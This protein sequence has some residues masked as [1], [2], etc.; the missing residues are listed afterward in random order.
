MSTYAKRRRG[1][2]YSLSISKRTIIETGPA[3]K[4]RVF[5]ANAP[6]FFHHRFPFF[7][8]DAVDDEILPP[9]KAPM[10]KRMQSAQ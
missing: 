6:F 8:D 1:A 3:E 4:K 7:K 5:G 10:E 9:L 2:F